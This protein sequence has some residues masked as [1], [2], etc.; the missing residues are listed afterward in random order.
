MDE[1]EIKKHLALAAE[2]IADAETRIRRQQEAITGYLAGGAPS[3]FAQR[4][5]A[6]LT[7]TLKTMQQRRER[8][9][10]ELGDE[11]A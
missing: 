3:E 7:E 6:L 11:E 10:S 8:L 1:G 2:H 4:H 5:L 9:L